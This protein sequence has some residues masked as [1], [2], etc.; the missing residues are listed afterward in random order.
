MVE[1][2]FIMITLIAGW[3]LMAYCPQA[4]KITETFRLCIVK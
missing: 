3:A 4:I 2:M 1:F